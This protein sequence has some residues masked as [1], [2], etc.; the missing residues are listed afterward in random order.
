MINF[1]SKCDG[2]GKIAAS[3]HWWEFWKMVPCPA[4]G[5]DGHAKPPGWP[6]KVEMKRLRPDPPPP[7]PPR[8]S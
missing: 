6:D 7:P 1:C 2:F 3:N 8:N 4:C 5:G